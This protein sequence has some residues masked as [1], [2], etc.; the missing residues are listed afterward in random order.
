MVQA[1][2]TGTTPSESRQLR[3]WQ[4]CLVDHGGNAQMKGADRVSTFLKEAGLTTCTL[5]KV[6]TIRL[7][8]RV[9]VVTI[10]YWE[11]AE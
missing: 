1:H 2:G 7:R 11:T 3:F 8:D 6:E 10:W 4:T 5:E 9:L